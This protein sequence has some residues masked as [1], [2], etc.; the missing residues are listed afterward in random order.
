[1][2]V[3]SN[4]P[5]EEHLLALCPPDTRLPQPWP[6]LFSV[7]W[8]LLYHTCSLHYS[9]Q[10]LSLALTWRLFWFCL[11]SIFL[12]AVPSEPFS[13][14]PI[15]THP[16]NY[17]SVIIIIIY[18]FCRGFSWMGCPHLYPSSYCF[19][20]ILC[21]LLFAGI[22]PHLFRM[23]F[24]LLKLL[25]VWQLMIL[26]VYNWKILY[27]FH[28]IPRLGIAFYLFSHH[29]SFFQMWM[30]LSTVISSLSVK[31]EVVWGEA[32]GLGYQHTGMFFQ[33]VFKLSLPNKTLFSFTFQKNFI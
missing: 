31:R 29:S 4:L 30:A 22:I 8:L 18:L 32:S 7:S 23:M 5:L 13:N 9:C 6:L 27:Y 1:M 19:V 26:S 33:N 12:H 17:T 3:V 25:I 21:I 28:S 10:M 14:H 15:P 11:C 16:S 20:Q 2:S 24:R